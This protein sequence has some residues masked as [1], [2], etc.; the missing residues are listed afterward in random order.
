MDHLP[1]QTRLATHRHDPISAQKVAVLRSLIVLRSRSLS[2]KSG[3]LTISQ[4]EITSPILRLYPLVAHQ[5]AGA[6]KKWLS[7]DLYDLDLCPR[8][9]AVLRSPLS[10][11]LRCLTISSLRPRKVAVLRSV[12]IWSSYD[13]VLRSVRD[14][15]DLDLSVGP[16][17]Q[18]GLGCM[19]VP[20]VLLCAHKESR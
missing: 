11:D 14:L 4:S 18:G 8:K 5:L 1:R 10:Y 7:Y 9:V 16:G 3:C 15:Y 17:R 20:P 12:T 13:L 6:R 2:A 19:A